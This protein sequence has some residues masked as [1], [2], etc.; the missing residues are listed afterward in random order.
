MLPPK[1]GRRSLVPGEVMVPTP[2]LTRARNNCWEEKV[3]IVAHPELQ[4]EDLGRVKRRRTRYNIH[5]GHGQFQLSEALRDLREKMSAAR[6]TTYEGIYNGLEALLR[7]TTPD[8]SE[9]KRKGAR[10]LFSMALRAVPKYI[11]QQEGL[12]ETYMEKTSSKSA[13]PTREI[14]S[15]IYDEL[16]AYGSSGYGWKQLKVIVRAHGVQVITDAIR[17]GLLDVEFSGCL[18]TLCMQI[19]AMDEA[20]SLFSALLS[21][22]QFSP[23]RTIYDKPNRILPMLWK[24]TEHSGNPSFQYR[25]L[26]NLI[27][28]GLLPLEWLATKEFGPVWTRVIQSLSPNAENL[29]ALLFLD[30]LLPLLSS[31]VGEEHVAESFA[32]N[33][34]LSEAG[35]NTFSSLLTTLASIM[36]LNKE[37]EGLARD[38]DAVQESVHIN[39]LFR[40]CIIQDQ[41]ALGTS[42][43]LP[44]LAEVIAQSETTAI[45]RKPFSYDALAKQ[46]R[47]G[48]GTH[49]QVYSQAVLFLC[50]VARCCGR[51]ALNSGLEYLQKAHSLLGACASDLT[52]I[53]KSLIVDSAFAFAEQIPNREHLDYAADMDIKFGVRRFGPGS[54]V[55]S[56]ISAGEES[57]SRAGF[58]WEEGISE[59][60]TATPMIVK[61]ISVIISAKEDSECENPYRPPPSLRWKT[62]KN[63]LPPSRAGSPQEDIMDQ[64]VDFQD[65]SPERGAT[66]VEDSQSELNDVAS[67]SPTNSDD[68]LGPDSPRLDCSFISNVSTSTEGSFTEASFISTSSSVSSISTRSVGARKTIDRAPRFN[69]E[70]LCNSQ[71]WQLFEESSL[72]STSSTSSNQGTE[73]TESRQHIDRA[74]R[75]GR[76]A[77]RSSQAWQLFDESDD[78]LSL[79]SVSSQGDQV[80]QDITD[81]PFANGRRSLHTCQEKYR[82]VPL[83]PAKRRILDVSDSEDEL[84]M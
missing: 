72:C 71:D 22:T 70:L 58:R 37:R 12:L 76:K 84:G 62:G 2:I 79:L 41:K 51:G 33:S 17:S 38:N 74:P 18:I 29:E 57:E 50:H 4:V 56:D 27:S 68:E 81:T 46:L 19:S 42:S 15:E 49:S 43:S 21:S 34:T 7:A 10:S 23:P 66:A 24:F 69:R 36:I 28:V 30:M 39:R 5:E 14:S 60:V 73:S 40:S 67:S 26:A 44:M 3:P 77:L 6:F 20:Q 82:S 48:R 11:A 32:S 54:S 13:I 53:F 25:E 65:I 31:A 61:K 45:V 80:L 83:K 9:V 8:K 63:S 16:E 75:F 55:H 47:Q 59:W 64:T 1:K 78:E 52:S 35:T